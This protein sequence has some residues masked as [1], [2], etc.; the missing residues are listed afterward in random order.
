MK[1][2]TVAI[3]IVVSVAL[4]GGAGYGAYYAMQGQKS[5]VEVVPVSNVNVGS[6]WWGSSESIY[7]TVTSQ[8]AQTVLL[9]E[10]YKIDEIYVKEGD[11]V[12]EGDPLFSYDMTLQ[13]LELEMEK[14]TL[15]TRELTMTKLEKDLEKLKKTPATASLEVNGFVLTASAEEEFLIEEETVSGTSDQENSLPEGET[16]PEEAKDP[17]ASETPGTSESQGDI[18]IENMEEVA[19]ASISDEGQTALV[20]CAVSYERLVAAI[21]ALFRAYGDDLDSDE[22]R[23]AIDEAVT[24]YR[25]NLADEVVTAG[26]DADGNPVEVREYVMKDSVKQA[27]GEEN[28]KTLETYSQKLDEYQVRLVEMMIS[29]AS[30]QQGA[31]LS[32]TVGDIQNEYGLLS[33]KQR[34]A[35]KNMAEF[36]ELEAIAKQQE[37]DPS[38]TQGSETPATGETSGTEDNSE[39][40]APSETEG[41]FGTGETPGADEPSETEPEAVKY[42]VTVSKDGSAPEVWERRPGETVTLSAE[43]EETKKFEGW[44]V[45]PS[46]VELRYGGPDQYVVEFTMPESDVMVKKIY[47]PLPDAIKSYVDNFIALSEKAMNENAAADPDYLTNLGTAVDYYQQWLAV[48]TNDF[49][50]EQTT[51]E[52]YQTKQEVQDYLTAQGSQIDLGANY[53]ALC[54]MY[55]KALFTSLNPD[56][57]DRTDLEKAS[58]IYQ[59]LGANWQDEL[60]Q[61]WQDEQSGQS[62]EG[63]QI[64]AIADMLKVYGVYL[65]FQEYQNLSPETAEEIRQEALQKV[66]QAYQELS[67][68]QKALVAGNQALV[69]TLKESGLWEET[70]P[71]S[72]LGDLPDGDFGDFGDGTGYTASELKEMI[73]SK[74]REIKECELTIR[75][76]EL[77]VSQRQRIVDGK[78]VKSTLDGTVLSIGSEDGTT[79]YDY[80]VKVANETGLFAKGA[81]NELALEKI[82]VGDTISGMMTNNGVSFTAVIK[83][84]SEYPDPDGSSMSFSYGTENTNA[85]YYPFY[86]L[87]DN[88]DG[89]EEG[90][91]EIQLSATMSDN[92]DAIYLE[93][94]FVRTG[95]DG[96]SYVFKQGEDGTLTKQYVTTGKSLSNYAIEIVEG[97]EPADKIAFPYGKSVV[98]GA[99]T[100]EVD[101]LQDAYM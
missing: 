61:S 57:L 30:A 77:A 33:T 40:E 8:V 12:K 5:P 3:S 97:L 93:K 36:R 56:A 81:M 79:D 75:E 10:E 72:E 62:E 23:S 25:R 69:D 82:H 14:L 41:A 48:S 90:E 31:A 9:N 67:D 65:L 49:A 92:S 18:R 7:G 26:Q 101:V 28:A 88:V 100:K 47:V 78:V 73:E 20:D 16:Q 2:K 91:A 53:K 38:N 24:Y 71:D 43:D 74:E 35:V 39:S 84:I 58:E 45:S 59:A 94:Y 50:D 19:S 13:E 85:S 66:Y 76:S 1:L 60:E 22:I 11:A 34:A 96:K 70:E 46:T 83:E 6:Y 87:L 54:M 29:E 27:L 80:F 98:E 95:N 37:T 89:I 44:E 99:K 63:A 86:A 52:H 42:K 4:V 15:Q 55:A 64:A 51:M 21:D 32:G 17:D 68:E